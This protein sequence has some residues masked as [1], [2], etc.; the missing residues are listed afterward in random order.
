M[1]MDT[2]VALSLYYAFISSICLH[3]FRKLTDKDQQCS[4]F[5]SRQ[6]Q[7]SS[8]TNSSSETKFLNELLFA[9]GGLVVLLLSIHTGMKDA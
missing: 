5:S 2:G 9:A 8:V 4:T 7:C 1:H 6:G 3:L